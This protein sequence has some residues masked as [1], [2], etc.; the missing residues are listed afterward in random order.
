MRGYSTCYG[1][2][3]ELADERRRNAQ[4][5]GRQGGRGRSGVGKIAGYLHTLLED[6]TR[7]VI[8]GE[9]ETSRGAVANQLIGTRIRLLEHERRV[10]ELEELEE[11]L[12]VIEQ[13]QEQ[14]GGKRWGA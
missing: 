11:R 12:I 3:P 14:R 13:T 5:G 2:R 8:D 10:K 7:R 9:L 1:H 4:K 6:L